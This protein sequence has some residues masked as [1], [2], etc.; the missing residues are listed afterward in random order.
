MSLLT[1]LVA[2]LPGEIK[3]PVHQFMAACAEL[4]RGAPGVTQNSIATTFNLSASEQTQLANFA[5]QMGSNTITRELV[6]DVLLLGEAGI[7][8]VQN[9]ANRLGV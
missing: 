5:S 2:P 8:T 3:L 4:R 1:R 7:Y 6:H 9:C